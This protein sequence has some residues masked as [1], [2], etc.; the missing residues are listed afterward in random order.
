MNLVEQTGALIDEAWQRFGARA[1]REPESELARALDCLFRGY[2]LDSTRKLLRNFLV[3]RA[4]WW[5]YTRG[6]D[7]PVAWA[8]RAHRVRHERGSR[9]AMWRKRPAAMKRSGR[10]STLCSAACAK[11]D[12]PIVK[13]VEAYRASCAGADA[14]AWLRA[15]CSLALKIDGSL[16][17]RKASGAQAKRLGKSDEARMLELH[18]TLGARLSAIWRDRADQIC[19]RVNEAALTCGVALVDAY[20][21][22]KA[23][24]QAIDYGDIE[25][26]A[27]NLVS[28]SDHA[29]YMHYKLDSRYRHI[30]LD[31]FQ[32]T[33][34]LQWLTL[35]SWFA[36]AAEAESR[37]VVFLVGDPKQSI[38]RFRGAEA[39]LFDQAAGYLHNEFGACTVPQLESRRCAPA[40]IEVVNRLFSGEPDF[41]GFEAHTAHYAS[42][43]GRVEVL[44]LVPENRGQTPFFA[45]ESRAS[46][47]KKVPYGVAE[48]RF[49]RRSRWT[50]TCA[51]K[52]RPGSS[53]IESIRS[54][55]SGSSWMTIPKA[56]RGRR[57]TRT[58]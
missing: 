19:Y 24:R 23:E 40:V 4:D 36:A 30:L 13:L 25:W 42:K 28:V 27:Y 11:Y 51:A 32:D 34:P 12:R 31:E 56:K 20:Q 3:R 48:S 54:S 26:H 58:S 37:P 53:S 9:T 14:E 15:A 35:K 8:L 49:S 29:V 21:S 33:N 41:R 50:K 16:R 5:A 38:Y 6:H 17:A 22:V 39:R 43:P 55:V 1:Q 18:E 57:A 44:P 45:G 46:D 10:S 52:R 7:D 47:P 2:G